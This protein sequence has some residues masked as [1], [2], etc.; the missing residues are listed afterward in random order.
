MK[1]PN[2]RAISTVMVLSLLGGCEYSA[3]QKI[4]GEWC[5]VTNDAGHGRQERKLP[6][7]PRSFRVLS[8]GN[9]AKDAT[10]VFFKGTIVEHADA[11]TFT[12]LPSQQSTVIFYAKDQHRVFLRRLEIRGADPDTF[13]VIEGPYSRDSQ[14]IYCGCIPMA[15]ENPTAFE[16]ICWSGIRETGGDVLVASYGEEF[17]ILEGIVCVTRGWSRDG[18]NYYYGPAVVR[19]RDYATMEVIDSWDAKDK[20]GQFSG[21]LLIRNKEQS[22]RCED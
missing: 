16:V 17:A 4:G 10:K 9:Y 20:H 8:G 13:E 12:V 5:Y 14:R 2:I 15:V 6:V 22:L 3:Y 18:K 21:D 11:P 19:G 7:D 1:L